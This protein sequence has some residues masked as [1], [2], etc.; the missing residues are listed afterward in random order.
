[1]H[2]LEKCWRL[3]IWVLLVLKDLGNVD[4]RD[5]GTLFVRRKIGIAVCVCWIPLDGG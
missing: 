2:G 3:E 1:M 4:E 5:W